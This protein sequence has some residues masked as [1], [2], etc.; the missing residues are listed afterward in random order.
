[1]NKFSASNLYRTDSHW[2]EELQKIH[3]NA[4]PQTERWL[5]KNERPIA[6]FEPQGN[7]WKI[8]VSVDGVRPDANHPCRMYLATDLA[9][10]QSGLIDL[11]KTGKPFYFVM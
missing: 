3:P 11:C 2:Y 8:S 10:R 7:L 4:K 1:M 5:Q 6:L 9:L